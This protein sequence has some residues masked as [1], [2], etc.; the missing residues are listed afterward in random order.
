MILG[1]GVFQIPAIKKAVS[2][3]YYVITVDYLPENIGHEFSHHYVSCSTVD[4]ACVLEA[5]EKLQID[6][7]CTFSSDIAVPT[8]GYVSEKLGLQGVTL[9]SGEI[10]ASNFHFR[11][12]I[13]HTD[14][15]FPDFVSGNKFDDIEESIF[16]LKRKLLANDADST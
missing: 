7:I 13:R 5:A 9:R 16:K 2:L 11:E 15:D 6:G 8:I 10:M 14:L 3:G 4:R 1:A 12:F